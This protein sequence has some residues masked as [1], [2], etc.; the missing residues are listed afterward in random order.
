MKIKDRSP[1]LPLL[2][3]KILD[4]GCG[5]YLEVHNKIVEL[6]GEENVFGIDTNTDDLKRFRNIVK[7]DAE[8]LSKLFK[9]N[10]FDSVF[11]GEIIEHLKNPFRFL[12]SVYSILK[13]DG[14]LIITIPQATSIKGLLNKDR[15]LNVNQKTFHLYSWCMNTFCSLIM[16]SGF[17]IVEKGYLKSSQLIS[18]G[19]SRFIYLPKRLCFGIYLVAKK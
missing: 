11:A 1:L 10:T 2:E 9:K 14:I 3:G 15:V 8:N 12:K 5:D 16:L 6:H 7:G 4:I 18:T 17:K 19:L 13:E